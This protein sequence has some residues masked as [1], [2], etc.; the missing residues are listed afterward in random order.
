METRVKRRTRSGL[1]HCKVTL[2]VF[3]AYVSAYENDIL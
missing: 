3:A 1:V 2:G